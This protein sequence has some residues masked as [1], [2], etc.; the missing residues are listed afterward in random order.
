MLERGM[1]VAIL[2]DDP[3]MRETMQHWLSEQGHEV[4][5]F[6][7]GD[8]FMRA[9]GRDSHDLY[10]LDGNLPDMQGQDVLLWL[11]QQR[12][13][14]TPVMFVTARDAEEDIVAALQAGAD[15]YLIKPVRRA[16]LLARMQAVLRR[17]YPELNS[18]RLD[19]PPYRFDLAAKR[20][21]LQQEEAGLTEKEY[22]LAL[23]LFRNI[24]R[25]VSRGHLLSVVW[26]RSPEL[27]TRTV[28]T[29]VSRVRAKLQLRPEFGFKLVPVYNYGYRLE[30]HTDHA[31]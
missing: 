9:L 21:F 14:T 8:A 16:E 19:E 12:N 6:G 15:D 13:N 11:R 31:D 30:R 3:E 18:D 17:I 24:G 10:L 20:V 26:G 1:R 23:F 29:H 4:V 25:L 5:A 22:E 27:A 28:D 7:R 2:E